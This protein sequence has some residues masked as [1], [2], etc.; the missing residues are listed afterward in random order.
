MA[1]KYKMARLRYELCSPIRILL[2]FAFV[3]FMLPLILK[4]ALMNYIAFPIFYFFGSYFV[5]LNFPSI[6]ESLHGK[7]IYIE[8]L[9]IKTNQI[10]DETF[11]KIYEIILNFILA[12]LFAFFAEY[13]IIQGVKNKPIVEILAI[14]GGNLSLYMK[15]QDII[16]NIILGICYCVKEKKEAIRKLSEDNK[17]TEMNE[18]NDQKTND[19]T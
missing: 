18:M 9:V 5:F 13:I 17:T 7:P 12:I 3:F 15:S 19:E 10:K 16:G 11:K 1:Y 6:G 14:I 8:D 4:N 2:P